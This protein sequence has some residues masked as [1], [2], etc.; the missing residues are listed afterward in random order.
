MK[1]GRAL[2]LAAV[3]VIASAC[4]H[5]VVQTGLAPSTT[6]VSKPWTATWIFGLVAA[7]PIDVTQ[8]CPSGI[9][10]V[11]TQMTLPN[12]LVSAVTIGI[13]DPREVTITCAARSASL[14]GPTIDIAANASQADREAAY[15][16]AVEL[17]MRSG[18]TVVI[19]F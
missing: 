2:K 8:Q 5:Q 7:Q 10:T 3:C 13:Y 4:Y 18:Q 1:V 14:R 15:I 16:N 19:R 6:V 9:A 12:W 17:S 11:S